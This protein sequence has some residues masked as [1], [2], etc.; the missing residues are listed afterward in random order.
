MQERMNAVRI[1]DIRTD[2]GTQS[3]AQ[4]NWLTVT[5]YAAD[6]AEGATFPPVV[7]YFDGGAY[8]LAD[9][10]HRLEA[11]KRLGLVEIDA[12]VKQGTRRDAILYSVKANA[13]HGLRRTN[14]D[15]RRAVT[16]LLEDEEWRQW[17][18]YRIADAC[19]V[20]Q[21]FVLSTKKS[22]QTVSSDERRYITKH[23]T[24]AVMNTANIGKPAMPV[25]KD[26][27]AD[28]LTAVAED[29]D[30]EETPLR[31][32]G[33][34]PA[35][36]KYCYTTHDDWECWE[37]EAWICGRCDHA[38]HDSMMDIAVPPPEP[39][40]S[41]PH[42]AYNAGNNEWYTPPEYINAA[43]EVMG[44]IDLDPATSEAANAVVGAACLFTAEDNGLLRHWQGRV[45]MNPPYASE[46]VGKFADKLA[47]HA[48][49]GDVSEAIV[50][51]NNA[52]ETAWFHT[53]A[54]VA[55]AVVF[56]RGRVR[57]WEPGGAISAPLQG[58]AVIYI[59]PSPDRFLAAFRRFGW[60]ATL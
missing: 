37:G 10:F 20:S 12:D 38:T 1:A 6:I 54:G 28:L 18:A 8:W 60:G 51:V 21:P 3:R 15:K 34:S 43:V 23:G 17:S 7:V 24:E 45:W 11:H 47:L 40:P 25:V 52:T 46:L 36:C 9:G 48:T 50:L 19:G 4:I 41:R 16:M 32:D 5:D 13:L 29:D 53:L 30:E 57:F 22:L 35:Y 27:P 44:G 31:Y 59:G 39:E 2:G 42:V 26:A 56:P 49:A 14:E 33:V 58:Q 55:S